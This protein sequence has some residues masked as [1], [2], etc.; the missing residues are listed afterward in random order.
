M[1]TYGQETGLTIKF[2]AFAQIFRRAVDWPI[3]VNT[4]TVISETRIVHLEYEPSTSVLAAK[5]F[6]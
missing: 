3:H 2:D 6:Y 1:D 5:H 4:R